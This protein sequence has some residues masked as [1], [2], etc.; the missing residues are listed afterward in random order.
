MSVLQSSLEALFQGPFE[1]SAV[2][3]T[4]LVSGYADVF[5]QISIYAADVDAI[6]PLTQDLAERQTAA[7]LFVAAAM[8][9]C[10]AA[11]G[12]G[13]AAK[14]QGDDYKTAEDVDADMAILSGAWETLAER[15]IDA[16][17]RSALTDIYTRV[18]AILSAEEVTLPRIS[19]MDVPAVPAS[20]LAYWLY[21]T[22]R[23]DT[24]VSLNPTLAPWLYDGNARVLTQ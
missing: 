20:V 2:A 3:N 1:D 4:A 17:V 5:A 19:G 23:G 15:S 16:D 21:D 24:L 22:E 14:A 12:E 10:F 18:S 6:V 8:A 7:D 13:M 11:L 9:S